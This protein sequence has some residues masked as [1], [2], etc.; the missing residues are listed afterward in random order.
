MDCKCTVRYSKIAVILKRPLFQIYR[1]FQKTVIIH[2]EISIEM[3][4]SLIRLQKA[5]LLCENA[6]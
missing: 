3:Q 4:P 6:V 5:F 2:I 1:Y